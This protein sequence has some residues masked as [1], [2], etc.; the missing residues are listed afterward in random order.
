VLEGMSPEDKEG[1]KDLKNAMVAMGLPAA[2]LSFHLMLNA[3]GLQG[4]DRARAEKEIAE[5][6]P[7]TEVVCPK[8]DYSDLGTGKRRVVYLTLDRVPKDHDLTA[9]LN[10]LKTRC[11]P[12]KWQTVLQHL[13]MLV[14]TARSAYAQIVQQHGELL[15]RL[16]GNRWQEFSALRIDKAN[17][18]LYL[19]PTWSDRAGILVQFEDEFSA[20]SAPEAGTSGAPEAGSA[21]APEAGTSG[22]K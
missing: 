1:F 13:S 22:T 20:A 7:I 17:T 10:K 15:R 18:T 16:A 6:S 12:D 9:E 21:S 2:R 8:V 14:Y 4:A 3:S 19:D 5:F 11:A